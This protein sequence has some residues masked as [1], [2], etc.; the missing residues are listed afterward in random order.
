[1]SQLE[2]PLTS[3]TSDTFAVTPIVEYEPPRQGVPRNA[4]PCRSS[5]HTPR[6][7]H[8]RR[9]TGQPEAA[10]AAVLS[11]T[12]RQAATFADAALRRALEVIDRRRP[13]SQLGPLLAPGLVDSVVSVG[14]SGQ[15]AAVLRRMRLQP[16]GD[17]PTA[18]EVFG[19]YSRGDRIHA[20]ACRVEQRPGN[21]WLVVAL[22]IG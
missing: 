7:P 6:Q 19:C 11:P 13:Q 22:H 18:A 4:T 10:R 2:C 21:R 14:R 12:M 3:S 9:P 1:M 5:A 16:V 20:I 8:S 15:G 17:P